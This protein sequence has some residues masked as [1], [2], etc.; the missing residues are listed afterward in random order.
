MDMNGA[1]SRAF[2]DANNA[3][4]I[5]GPELA[6]SDPAKMS[7]STVGDVTTLNVER[8]APEVGYLTADSAA[9]NNS[10]TLVDV[11]GL[12]VP[13]AAN[14]VYLIEGF[15]AYSSNAAAD[16]KFGWTVPTGA[17]GKWNPLAINATTAGT[18]SSVNV[19]SRL[20]TEVLPAGATDGGLLTCHVKGL[21]AVGG[22]A[23]VLQ[24][25]FAQNTATAVNTTVLAYSWVSALRVG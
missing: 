3:L 25:Q 16:A 2:D 7:V 11:T 21:L 23:G 9:V 19:A 14:A 15:L 4:R 18:A 20:W 24:A 5:T 13:V 12:A 8:L 10:T 6:S 1:L 22:T 17:T